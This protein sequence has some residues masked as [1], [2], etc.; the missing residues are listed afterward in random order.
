MAG[1]QGLSNLQSYSQQIAPIRSL[2]RDERPQLAASYGLEKFSVRYVFLQTASIVA[3][4]CI[5][6]SLF[7][8]IVIR[9]AVKLLRET[10]DTMHLYIAMLSAAD[11]LLSGKSMR[12][13]RS[14]WRVSAFAIPA[15]LLSSAFV[16]PTSALLCGIIHSSSWFGFASS[17]LFLTLLNIDKIYF[18]A[19][20]NK[21][22]PL[23]KKNAVLVSIA[24]ASMS[25]A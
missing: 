8:V 23:S 6:A 14:D 18:F 25:L 13:F 12:V 15:E 16:R 7:G 5:A 9:C 1:V 4:G 24:V 11:L 22:H 20:P 3:V 10:A 21:Y 2:D 19:W 17:G